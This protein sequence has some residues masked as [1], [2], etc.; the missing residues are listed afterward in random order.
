M[1]KFW[2]LFSVFFQSIHPIILHYWMR[3]ELVKTLK[4]DGFNGS[5]VELIGLY[6]IRVSYC[7]VLAAKFG[8]LTASQE[9]DLR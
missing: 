6:G 3:I 7:Y 5:C 2:A 4:V 9:M 8:P 1:T